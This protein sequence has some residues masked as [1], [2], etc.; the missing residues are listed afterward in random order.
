MKTDYSTLRLAAAWLSILGGMMVQDAA[1]AG[2]MLCLTAIPCWVWAWWKDSHADAAQR[3]G[4]TSE[5]K[6]STE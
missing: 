6:D 3:P 5:P 1:S 2:V 4:Q